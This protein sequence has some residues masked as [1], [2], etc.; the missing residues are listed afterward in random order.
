MYS[1]L[2]TQ[3]SK[4]KT[5]SVTDTTTPSIKRVSNTAPGDTAAAERTNFP[6]WVVME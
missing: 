5:Y 3:N 2:E 1:K 4:P 6:C